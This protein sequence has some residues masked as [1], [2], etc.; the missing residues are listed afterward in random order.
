MN[1]EQEIL[2]EA[3]E[4]IF[5]DMGALPDFTPDNSDLLFVQMTKAC[6]QFEACRRA[7][8]LANKLSAGPTKARHMSRI[9][10]ALNRIRGAIARIEKSIQQLENLPNEWK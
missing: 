3:L 2:N 5:E 8:S 7:M 6:D 4:A 9:M 10:S 1:L